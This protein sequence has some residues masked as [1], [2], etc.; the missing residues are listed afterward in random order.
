MA[1]FCIILIVIASVLEIKAFGGHGRCR[2]CKLTKRQVSESPRQTF[3]PQ[4][5][6]VHVT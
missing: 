1:L 5:V 6:T 2:R 4:K 3:H